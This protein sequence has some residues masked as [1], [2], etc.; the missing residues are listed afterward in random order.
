M[1]R[2]AHRFQLGSQVEIHNCVKGRVG[3]SIGQVRRGEAAEILTR[4]R[5]RHI[6]LGE[7]IPQ[8]RRQLPLAC[9]K[10]R[11]KALNFCSPNA[12]RSLLCHMHD[13]VQE[14]HCLMP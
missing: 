8:R 3:N 12:L 6:D 5:L 9:K 14:N 13:D 7:A 10:P 11:I 1:A 4:G 2:R